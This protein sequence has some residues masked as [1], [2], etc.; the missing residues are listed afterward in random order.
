MTITPRVDRR[1]FLRASGVALALPLLESMHPA[2]ARAAVESP[3]RLVTICS[4][5]GLYSDSWFPTT[6]GTDYDLL[7]ARSTDNGVSWSAPRNLNSNAIVDI[8]N[9]TFVRIVGDSA[10]RWIAVWASGDTLEGRI[11]V[12]GDIL[13]AISFDDGETWSAPAQASPPSG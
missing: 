10:G 2:F 13:Y 7:F 12:D 5:L 8:G 6:T 4:T 11:G 1:T 9:D 3:R